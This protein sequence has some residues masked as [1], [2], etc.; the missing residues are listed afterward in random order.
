MDGWSLGVFNRELSALYQ[1]FSAGKELELPEL[2]VQPVD[3]ACWEHDSRRRPG[4]T[5]GRILEEPPGVFVSSDG[6][7]RHG[8]E[9]EQS[10][11]LC[12]HQSEAIPGDVVAALR[13]L[14]RQEGCTLSMTLFAAVVAQLHE[15]TGQQDIRVNI[16]LAART[17]PE[18][19]GLIG[20]FRTRLILRTDVS[21]KP[22]FRQLL[23][24][25]K[26]V[27][28]NAYLHQ[29]V[30]LETVFPELGVDHPAFWRNVHIVFNFFHLADATAGPL[31]L[32]GLST[33]VLQRSQ[34]YS[35]SILDMSVF[36]ETDGVSVLLRSMR[37]MFSL[38]TIRELVHDYQALLR[39]VVSEPDER[40]EHAAAGS[41]WSNDKK[42]IGH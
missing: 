16:P 35:R 38:A 5:A 29:D 22:T 40:I 9:L 19:E 3:V 36:D 20:C 25:V 11:F 28:S 2:P 34:Y 27:S 4:E 12:V 18:V 13:E 14:G 30:S 7:A 33:T 23:G 17:R 31:Q 24:R 8:P 37:E 26:V 32:S 41:L 1:A 15:A 10:D 6:P 42:T 21:G 39:R